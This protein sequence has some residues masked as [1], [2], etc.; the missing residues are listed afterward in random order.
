[1]TMIDLEDFDKIGLNYYIGIST[2]DKIQKSKSKWKGIYRIWA[3]QY[4]KE[5]S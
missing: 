1:M 3:N 2:P 5:L 4:K